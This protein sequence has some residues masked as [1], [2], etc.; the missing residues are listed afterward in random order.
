MKLR[1]LGKILLYAAAGFLGLMLL[2]TLALKLALDRVPAYQDEI[3]ELVNR[4]TGFHIRFSHVEPTLRWYGPE[5]Y[6]DHP[7]LRSK[8]DRRVLARAEGGRIAADIWRLI[9]NQKLLAGRLQLDGPDIVIARLGPDAF[10][11]AS[12]IELRQDPAAAALSLDDLPDGT[13]DIRHGRVT[14]INWNASLP[15]LALSGVDLELRRDADELQVKAAGRLPPALG[16]SLRVVGAVHGLTDAGTMVW[17][18]DAHGRDISFA[19]WRLLLPEYLGG[20]DA[21]T[22]AFELKANGAGGMPER[23][24]LDFSARSVVTGQGAAG[25][26]FDEIGGKLTLTHAQDRWTLIGQGV[27]ALQGGRHDPASQFN[28]TWRANEAGLLELRARAS[29]LRAESLAPLTGLLPQ[30][31]IR[32]RLRVLGLTGEWSDA[33]FELARTAAAAPWRM[34]VRAKFHDAGFAPIGRAPGMRGLSGSVA[35]DQDGGRVD[36]DS[37][38]VAIAWPGEWQQPPVLEVVTATLYWKLTPQ[39][40]LVA[41]PALLARNRDAALHLQA[42]WRQPSNGDSPQLTVVGGVENGDVTAAHNY[43]PR[44]LIAPKALEWLDRAFLA[45]RMPH[46]DIIVNGPVRR[47]PF[48]DGSGLFLAKLRIEDMTLDY[49]AGWAPLENLSGEAEFRNEGLS[50]QLLAGDLST[51]KPGGVAIKSGSVRFA[52]FKTGELSVHATAD[53]DAGGALDYL[54]ATPLDA[55]TD[56]AFSVVEASGPLHADIELFLPFR[57]FDQRRVL[58][59]VQANGLTL[60]RVKS[61]LVATELIGEADIDGGQIAHADVRGRLLGGPFRAQARSPKNRPV[62]RTQLDIR[63]TLNG[64]ALR[65]A[66]EL[67]AAVAISGLSDWHAV[68]KMAPDPGRERSLR[69]SGSLAGFEFKLPEPLAKPYGQPLPSWVE[70]EWPPAAGAQLQFALG[71]LLRGAATLQSDAGGWRLG[72]AALQFG[73]EDPEFSDSQQVN[74]GGDIARLDLGGWLRLHSPDKDSR[75]L[76]AYLHTAKLEIG[77]V[78]Y[79]GL[80]FRGV[81]V[82]LT[83]GDARW[84]LALSGADVSGRLSAPVAADAPEPWDLEFARLKFDDAAASAGAERPPAADPHGIPAITFHSKATVWGE[85]N[86]GDVQA[87]LTRLNDGISLD[88]LAV[89]GPSFTLG[90]QGEW[91]GKDAGQCRIQGNLASTDVQST[92]KQLGYADVIAAKSGHVVFDLHWAGAPTA[93]A[94]AESVGHVQVSLDKGQLIGIKPGAGRVLGL[95]SVAALPRRLALDFSDL[96]DKGFAFDTARGDFDLRDG[97]AYTDNVLVKGP[98]AE[99]GMIGRVG[100]KNKD[101][102]QTAVVTGSIGN[103]LPAAALLGG[104]VLGAAVLVFTQVFKQP[105]KGL[106]RGYYRI[107]GSWDNPTVER[108]KSAEAAAA[109][110]EGPK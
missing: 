4:R 87:R 64:D 41:T 20:L 106:A 73:T 15:Q 2:A 52:D 3:K 93:D 28:V 98:A 43:L 22:G 5:L 60:A 11:L 14:V 91:R 94:L 24:V 102:D 104:P 31:D 46:A 53:G 47:F 42:A 80:A 6:F 40:L 62:K 1:T 105:L 70:I 110:A 61:P 99:I 13:L 44:A 34:R 21:G 103:S 65:A 17:S 84:Q 78:D 23:A 45:G 96:T 79:L 72:R 86:F 29:Y 71:A 30:P 50:A 90:A 69:I 32:D 97:N 88:R 27:Q 35:G 39:E 67:P 66:L 109:T 25:A 68:L 8:D 85:R 57:D 59:H 76:S 89:T 49:Q 58:V 18:G 56:Q 63:G 54:R 37:H 55:L 26:R 33:S 10:A 16:G 19:G 38:T 81:G 101:Y 100:L 9:F 108:I 83:V 7:E 74:I 107:T 48:R 36:L 82:E 51:G 92:L 12:E 77:E 95:A 75:P